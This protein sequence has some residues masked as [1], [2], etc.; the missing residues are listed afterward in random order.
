MERP[1]SKQSFRFPSLAEHLLVWKRLRASFRSNA[2]E[3]ALPLHRHSKEKVFILRT[4]EASTTPRAAS[5]SWLVPAAPW[6][7]FQ[8]WTLSEV[9]SPVWH[10]TL[11]PR[12]APHVPRT[13]RTPSGRISV[14]APALLRSL[15]WDFPACSLDPCPE[16]A[17]I[18][19][20]YVK[21]PGPSW[22]TG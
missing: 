11:A 5:E 15:L 7:T 1:S 2:D 21:D 14:P 22:M 17:V 20:G 3:D 19:A 6:S 12:A 18:P 4:F 10:P 13:T 16:P 9:L 8:G